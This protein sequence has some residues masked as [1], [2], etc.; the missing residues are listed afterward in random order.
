LRAIAQIASAHSSIDRETGAMLDAVAMDIEAAGPTSVVRG[1][2]R[3]WGALILRSHLG[4]GSFGDVYRA[5][6]PRLDREVALKL[7]PPDS[8][9]TPQGSVVVSEGRALAKVRHPNVVTVYGADRID[10]R[11]GVWMECIEGQTLAER[12]GAGGPLTPTEAAAIG[13]DLARALAAV[14]NAGLLHRDV[15]AQNVMCD[16]GGRV[17]LT[18]FGTAI[19]H[20]RSEVAGDASS[21]ASLEAKSLPGSVCPRPP[22][23]AGTPLYLAPEVLDGATQT[24][25]SDIYALGVLLFHALTGSFPLTGRTLRD[26]HVRHREGRRTRLSQARPDLPPALVFVVDRALDPDPATRF[27]MAEEMARE[28]GAVAADT[29]LSPTPAR[30]RRS[31]WGVAAATAVAAVGAAWLGD[32]VFFRRAAPAAAT[33]SD[34][35]LVASFEDTSGDSRAGLLIER[36][37]REAVSESPAFAVATPDR[38][39]KVRGYMRRPPDS[40]LDPASAREAALRDGGIRAVITGYVVGTGDRPAVAVHIVS[41]ASGATVATIKEAATGGEMTRMLD[42]VRA[43]VTGALDARRDA[44]PPAVARYEHVTTASFEALRTYMEGRAEFEKSNLSRAADLFV[45]AIEL[46]ADF[47]LAH[48]W[49]GWSR[50]NLQAPIDENANFARGD[51]L[52]QALSPEERLWAHGSH[53]YGLKDH[54]G[55]NAAFWA[56]LQIDPLH[57]W[58]LSNLDHYL[59]PDLREY[60]WVVSFWEQQAAARPNDLRTSYRTALALLTF[61]SRADRAWRY[62]DRFLELARDAPDADATG[63]N[64]AFALL[65]PA[66]DAWARGHV[67]LAAERMRPVCDAPTGTP[68]SVRWIHVECHRLRLTLGQL[69]RAAAHVPE[70][71][72]R[73]YAALLR[74]DRDTLTRLHLSTPALRWWIGPL[75]GVIEDDDPRDTRRL[76]LNFTVRHYIDLARGPSPETLAWFAERWRMAPAASSPRLAQAYADA[77]LRVG[78]SRRAVDVLRIATANR[79]DAITRRGA[80]EWLVA[81][82]AYADLLRRLRRDSEA[83]PVERD[84]LAML[85]LAD[86]D[87]VIA[88]R[89]RARYD[90]PPPQP[91]P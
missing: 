12:I 67:M 2:L 6:D 31:T 28:L 5:W 52:A 70:E 32:S 3:T 4:S 49:L 42:A 43:G 13:A 75:I 65:A 17:V 48:T 10:G 62:F 81:R 53:L 57:F 85:F 46:D 56:L 22:T 30:V 7:L 36:A 50:F 83:E 29:R 55:A 58:A 69:Q 90:R 38:I 86:S 15:K 73:P 51:A 23:L 33:R 74:G 41:P 78:D 44:L 80:L 25:Q 76:T 61:E 82:S 39:N 87:H 54:K 19:L 63:L 68:R 37:V 40:P 20:A 91:T 60:E 9:G 84:L 11:V 88:A 24:P 8:V 72:D 59:R 21:E 18:D 16:P 14:H 47:A 45:R 34:L 89:L 27:R 35:V 26:V 79:R 66:W 1:D 77:L 64:R 71:S